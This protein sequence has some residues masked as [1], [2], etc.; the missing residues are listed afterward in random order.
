MGTIN[1]RDML[2]K[3]QETLESRTEYYRI[4]TAPMRS[5]KDSE[6]VN[7]GASVKHWFSLTD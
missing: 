7:S 2:V 4:R 3:Q 1:K 5:E 6:M